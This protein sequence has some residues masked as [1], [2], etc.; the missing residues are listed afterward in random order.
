MTLKVGAAVLSPEE[1]N[2]V[3]ELFAAA[4]SRDDGAVTLQETLDTLALL[5]VP[6]SI[7]NL[8]KGPQK[9]QVDAVPMEHALQAILKRC[10]SLYSYQELMHAF[11]MFAEA[12]GPSG[13]ITYEALRQGLVR[14]GGGQMLETDI[15]KLLAE[16]VA[17]P[18]D[19]IDYHNLVGSFYSDMLPG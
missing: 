11:T 17:S 9:G 13:C 19:L 16:V 2:A 10:P 15:E 6:E 8:L 12:N 1:A 7:S 4:G 14:N 5:R 3:R 18:N